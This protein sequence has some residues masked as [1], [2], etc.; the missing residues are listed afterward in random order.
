MKKCEWCDNL[1][2]PDEA[3]YYFENETYNLSYSNVE[4]CLCGECAVKAIDDKVDG[5]YFETCENC[6]RKFD[7]IEDEWKFENHF[8]WDSGADL[9]DNWDEQIL[10]ADCAIEKVEMEIEEERRKNG[11]VDDGNYDDGE[12]VSAYDAALI[13]LS[14][15]KDEDYTFGYT[16]EEL[17]DALR[18]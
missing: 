17:E 6:G 3:E 10:C 5:V 1:F 8:S 14:H 12:G 13:W 2:D 7:M 11:D 4:K 18:S 15:G 16:E 9:R